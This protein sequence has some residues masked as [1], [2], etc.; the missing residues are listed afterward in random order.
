MC[1]YCGDG[2][3]LLCCERCPASFHLLCAE[4][5]LNAIPDGDWY[6]KQCTAIVFPPPAHF[7]PK[8]PIAS[9]LIRHLQKHNP[10]VFTLPKEIFEVAKKGKGFTEGEG[11]R[12]LGSGMTAIDV[13][14]NRIIQ[15]VCRYFTYFSVRLPYSHIYTTQQTTLF[16]T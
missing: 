3:E 6:C 12:Q 14:G 9:A 10:H 16:N 1:D 8:N 5:P 11:G 15:G 7:F 13:F 2:G 4:P